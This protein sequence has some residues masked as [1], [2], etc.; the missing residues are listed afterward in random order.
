VNDT[1]GNVLGTA[2][3]FIIAYQQYLFAQYEFVPS[4]GKL[5]K[6]TAFPDIHGKLFRDVDLMVLHSTVR[7]VDESDVA[8][9][10]FGEMARNVAT[11]T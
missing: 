2:P 11:T 7:K 6:E 10:C 1:A 8:R 3:A 4:F 9:G 5:E